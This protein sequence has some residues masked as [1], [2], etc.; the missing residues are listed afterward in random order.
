[1]GENACGRT[2]VRMAGNFLMARLAAATERSGARVEYT[3]RTETLVVNDAKRVVGV[4]VRQ[5]DRER[6][7]H[8]RRGVVLTAGGF[9]TNREMVAQHVPLIEQCGSKL[10]VEACDGSAIRMGMGAGADII[11]MSA[12]QLT[13]PF[14]PHRL[15]RGILVNQHGQRFINEDTDYGRKARACVFGQDGGAFLIVDAAIYEP[16]AYTMEADFRART[17]RELEQLVSL[18]PGSLQVTLAYYNRFA[19]Q[20]QDPLFH[21]GPELVEPLVTP[22]YAAFVV[23]RRCQRLEAHRRLTRSCKMA[24]PVVVSPG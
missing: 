13:F 21:K 22:P 16:L 4:V 8:A 1:M 23:D 9:T 10:E 12:V 15:M 6:F 7:V 14:T 2:P 19:K 18:P 3:A 20:R 5:H 11:H 24:L 17:V